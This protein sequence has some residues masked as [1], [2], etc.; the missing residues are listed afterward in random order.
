MKGKKMNKT[1]TKPKNTKLVLNTQEDYDSYMKLSRSD[2]DGVKKRRREI[3]K[4]SKER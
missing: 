1:E 3:E 4:R 2:K